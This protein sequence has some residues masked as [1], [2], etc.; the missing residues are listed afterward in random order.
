MYKY[1]RIYVYIHAAAAEHREMVV[2]LPTHSS[3]FQYERFDDSQNNKVCTW[4]SVYGS[5]CV[6]I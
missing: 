6:Y 3:E 2:A 5:L 1:I 4:Y